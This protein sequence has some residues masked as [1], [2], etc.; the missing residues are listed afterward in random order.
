MDK[1]KIGEEKKIKT[2]RIVND[3]GDMYK[4]RMFN[5]SWLRKLF[6]FF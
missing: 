3:G 5:P 6:L 1:R 2:A 4:L